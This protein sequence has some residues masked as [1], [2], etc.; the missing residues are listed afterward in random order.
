[1]DETAFDF[2]SEHLQNRQWQPPDLTWEQLKAAAMNKKNS[3]SGADSISM[4]LLRKLPDEAWGSVDHY[5]A[6]HRE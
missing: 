4:E 6:E 2:F 1:M 5:V 3:A